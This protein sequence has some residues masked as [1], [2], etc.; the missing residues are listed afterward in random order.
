[1]S[2]T[3]EFKLIRNYD[4]T[5]PVY[6]GVQENPNNGILAVE[7]YPAHLQKKR[8]AWELFDLKKD[9][10]E[11][12]NVAGDREYGDVRAMLRQKLE[13]WQCETADPVSQI[14]AGFNVDTGNGMPSIDRVNENQRALDLRA[15]RLDKAATSS[16]PHCRRSQE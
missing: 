4:S 16:N 5:P 6:Q 9:P 1:M 7:D 2:R 13:A 10:L 8:A 3:E 12:N 15:N 14:Y 11:R